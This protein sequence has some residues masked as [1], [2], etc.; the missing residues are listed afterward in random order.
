MQFTD[1]ENF[2]AAGIGEEIL[3]KMWEYGGKVDGWDLFHQG[4]S[5]EKGI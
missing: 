1:G 3:N 5:L 4:R 2:L